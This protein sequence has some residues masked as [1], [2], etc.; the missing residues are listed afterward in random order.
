M[1]APPSGQEKG[2]ADDSRKHADSLRH[3]LG[4]GRGEGDAEEQAVGGAAGIGAEPAAAGQEHTLL[5][6]RQEE[7]FFDGQRVF[8]AGAGM[9]APV[10]FEP[11]LFCATLACFFVKGL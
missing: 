10:D 5:D 4:C 3:Q 8:G 1:R 2:L 6:G 7:L 9:F 11:V